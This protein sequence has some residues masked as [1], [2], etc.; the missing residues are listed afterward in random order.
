[1]SLTDPIA[2]AITSIRNAVR[3]DKK[4]LDIPASKMLAG[5]LKALRQKKFIYYVKNW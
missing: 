1:M 4:Q 5:I 3:T 2:D